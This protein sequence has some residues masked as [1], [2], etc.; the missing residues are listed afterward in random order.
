MDASDFRRT[1]KVHFLVARPARLHLVLFVQAQA[2]AALAQGIILH[3]AVV[4][5]H[6]FRSLGHRGVGG[7]HE[8]QVRVRAHGVAARVVSGSV[9]VSAT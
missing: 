7:A 6:V 5:Q 8:G 9:F 1:M 4:G 2:D 3:P